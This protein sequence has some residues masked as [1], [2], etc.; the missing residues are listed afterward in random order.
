MIHAFDGQEAAI[1]TTESFFENNVQNFKILKQ[2]GSKSNELQC[3][4]HF[5]IDQRKAALS[6]KLDLMLE[7]KDNI[8]F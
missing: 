2:Y 7:G 3:V 8:P 5:I 4:Q 1:Q 6:K